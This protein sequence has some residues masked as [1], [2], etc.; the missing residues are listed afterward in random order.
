MDGMDDET[1]RAAAPA[2]LGP[3]GVA[4]VVIVALWYMLSNITAAN[5][6]QSAARA[7]S[8]IRADLT[9][10]TLIERD[11]GAPAEGQ[12]ALDRL[13]SGLDQRLEV[14][15]DG[16][17]RAERER[18][19]TM[20]SDRIAAA[21]S[22]EPEPEDLGAVMDMQFAAL[23]ADAG[24]RADAASYAMVRGTYLTAVLAL[25]AL[26]VAVTMTGRH[27]AQRAVAEARD[28]AEGRHR[29]LLEN[30][31]LLVYVIGRDGTLEYASPRAQAVYGRASSRVESLVQQLSPTYAEFGA[32]LVDQTV[33]CEVPHVVQSANGAWFEVVV[34]DHRDHRSIEGL[35]VT[36]RDISERVALESLLRRQATEDAL[37]G[38]TNRRG[39][40]LAL[41]AAVDSARASATSLGVLLVDLDGFKQVNDE[42][43]HVAG[44]EVLAQI[45]A[46][47]RDVVRTG[48]QVARY[49]GDEFAV[50]VERLR[51]REGAEAVARRLMDAL[52]VPCLVGDE[53]ISFGASIGIAIGSGDTAPG[54]L[55]DAA[56]RAMYRAKAA[57]G[58]CWRWAD[59]ADESLEDQDAE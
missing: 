30:A 16:V 17:G 18:L 59:A 55:L 31:P 2:A 38:T 25:L 52:R 57:G 14:A 20:V 8:A 51:D 6:A 24:E 10:L 33:E 45:G 48:E 1:K 40:D 58:G 27:R 39:L 11:D 28:S 56:D 37:T 54:E 19:R 42:R 15:L 34:S 43:G 32:S 23:A 13:E 50:I 44:D 49:G 36:A 29:A 46:R 9:T 21:R 5:D 3:A 12:A 41:D 7:A 47:L 22:G 35:V 4:V 26:L 53:L